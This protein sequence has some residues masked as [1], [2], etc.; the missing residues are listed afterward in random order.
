MSRPRDAHQ[1]EELM[2]K[3]ELVIAGRRQAAP[4]ATK[5]YRK[6]GG[7]GQ[8]PLRSRRPV[9]SCHRPELSKRC[10]LGETAAVPLAGEALER[11]LLVGRPR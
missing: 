11:E 9:L 5:S 7:C 2:K 3:F 6:P 8:I 4:R 10:L 1:E